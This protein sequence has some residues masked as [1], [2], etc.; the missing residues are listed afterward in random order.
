[1]TLLSPGY[2][3]PVKIRQIFE[4]AL[5]QGVSIGEVSIIGGRGECEEV[6]VGDKA[7]MHDRSCSHAR[8]PRGCGGWETN[9]FS[10][11]CQL[12]EAVFT[13]RRDS[14]TGAH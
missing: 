12:A 3:L 13:Y 6:S 10:F 4:I 1:M 11:I 8:A 9:S 14:D 2:G 5:M 7:E